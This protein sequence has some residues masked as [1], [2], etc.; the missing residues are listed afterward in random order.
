MNLER[1]YPCSQ[2]YTVGALV[3][4]LQRWIQA[5]PA[6]FTVV[7]C[8]SATRPAMVLTCFIQTRLY[9]MY[10]RLV[11][12][13]CKCRGPIGSTLRSASAA[14]RLEDEQTPKPQQA[15][16]RKLSERNSWTLPRKRVLKINLKTQVK[17]P[18]PKPS[19]PKFRRPQDPKETMSRTPRA[20]AACQPR[21]PE[22]WQLL[23]Y[24][25]SLI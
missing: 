23:F 9:V 4:E 24:C 18:N 3:G 13:L 25:R 10:L 2:P 22:T 6:P 20:G 17:K 19:K 5:S 14:C 7:W 21:R 12:V 8:A 15:G 11:S 16:I 1:N